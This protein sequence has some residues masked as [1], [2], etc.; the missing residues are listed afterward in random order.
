MTRAD[1][2]P[3]LEHSPRIDRV[4]PVE[5]D[6]GFR[7]LLRMKSDL[8]RENKGEYDIVFDIHNSL[9]S[10]YIRFAMGREVAV[11]KK[12]T[13]AK[14][15]LVHR[16]VNRLHPV[17]PI[18]LRYLEVGRAFGL[19][20][21]GQGLELF[22][23]EMLPPIVHDPTLPTIAFAPGARHATKRWPT[24]RFAELGR[25]LREH[26]LCRIILLGSA[27]ERKLCEDVRN[28]IG[29]E[30]VVN[31]AGALTWTETAATID[32]CEA[33]V[34]NDSA[35]THIAAARRRPV[36]TIFGATVQEFGFAPFRTPSRVV[37]NEGLYCR[38]CTTIGRA[39][40]PE[41]HFRCMLDIPAEEVLQAVDELN[42]TAM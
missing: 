6:W 42:G 31:L 36:V 19:E 17:I 32:L 3:L 41:K 35:V 23:G 34:T 33:V 11:L 8:L 14:W 15:M 7:D 40:C 18:P 27:E 5:R 25:G 1:F 4:L 21:D 26:R 12:P 22:T 37:E 39:D 24:E 2:V 28:G 10:R 20:D 29:G 30:N 16:K 38:P 9:R 13:F